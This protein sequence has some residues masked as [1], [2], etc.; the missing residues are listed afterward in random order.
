MINVCIKCLGKWKTTWLGPLLL[1][2][3]QHTKREQVRK[4]TQH[5][6]YFRCDGSVF[7]SITL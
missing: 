4:I 3:S 7:R 5:K 2:N 6:H 1:E